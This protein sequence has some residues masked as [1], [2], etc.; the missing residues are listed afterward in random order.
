MSNGLE[1]VS[2][3]LFF[4]HVRGQTGIPGSAG[5]IFALDEWNVLALRVLITLGETKIN[6]VNIIFCNLCAAD[7]EVVR[8]DVSMDNSFVVDLLDSLDHLLGDEAAGFQIEFSFALHEQIFETGS[9]HVHDHDV[10]LVLLV[11]FVGA[12]VVQLWNVSF[13][14]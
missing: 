6:D 1:V 10:E 5:E 11:G 4:S 14:S 2:P 12:D 8:L 9:E 3:R 7:E 13:S